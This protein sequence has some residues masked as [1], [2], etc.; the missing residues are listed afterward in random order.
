M[1]QSEHTYRCRASK[2]FV[3]IF[4]YKHFSVSLQPHPPPPVITALESA[5]L[6][7]YNDNSI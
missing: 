5:D 2:H 4:I 1:G 3:K 7:L 6:F